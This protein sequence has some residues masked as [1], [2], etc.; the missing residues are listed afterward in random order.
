MREN[1]ASTILRSMRSGSAARA[2]LDT[3]GVQRK[4]RF[5]SDLPQP[6]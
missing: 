4:V 5:L 6:H 1:L 2:G 3:S